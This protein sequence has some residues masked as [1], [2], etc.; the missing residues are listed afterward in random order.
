MARTRVDLPE[1]S[2]PS[3]VTKMPLRVP[4]G[5]CAAVLPS[6]RGLAQGVALRRRDVS[7]EEALL[8]RTGAAHGLGVPLDAEQPPLGEVFGLHG[9]DHAVRGA[10]R[11][12]QSFGEVFDPLMVIRVD[13]D[14][15]A[16]HD[17]RDVRPART[18]TSCVGC[19][20]GVA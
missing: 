9:L 19:H 5:F 20:L 11:H 10:A 3:M 16:A 15:I 12:D 17:L 2:G 4:C 18:S 7:L 14:H 1:K 8:L 13:L 6:G